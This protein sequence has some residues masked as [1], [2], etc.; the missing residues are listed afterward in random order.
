MN[1][2]DI[3]QWKTSSNCVTPRLRRLKT[4]PNLGILFTH[5]VLAWWKKDSRKCPSIRYLWLFVLWM[6][7]DYVIRVMP[8]L[9]EIYLLSKTDNELELMPSMKFCGIDKCKY[10]NQENSMKFMI[11]KEHLF[12]CFHDAWC[13]TD[14]SFKEPMSCYVSTWSMLNGMQGGS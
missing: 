14:M 1:H 11:L 12:K 2:Y 5:R 13:A 4:L 8:C 10:S 6:T 3:D 7:A 9:R